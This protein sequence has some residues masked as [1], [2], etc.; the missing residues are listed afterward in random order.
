MDRKLASIQKITNTK[1][2]PMNKEPKSK[3]LYKTGKISLFQYSAMRLCE[4]IGQKNYKGSSSF[5]INPDY[6]Q[7]K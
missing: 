7:V 1:I 3:R 2:S 5:I 4:I 6:K